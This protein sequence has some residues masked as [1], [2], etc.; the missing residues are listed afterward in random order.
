MNQ[1]DDPTSEEV[2]SAVKQILDS[3]P[4]EQALLK[5]GDTTI[6]LSKGGQFNIPMPP[7]DEPPEYPDVPT[8]LK[9]QADSWLE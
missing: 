3:Q 8:K 2:A 4:V 1:S 9:N 7:M 6:V 5:F